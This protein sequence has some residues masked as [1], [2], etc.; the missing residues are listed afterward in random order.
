[1]LATFV[2]LWRHHMV[3][4]GLA[5]RPA[6]A[7]G[8]TAMRCAH[9]P[10]FSLACLHCYVCLPA[11]FVFGQNAQLERLLACPASLSVLLWGA[12]LSYLFGFS[13]LPLGAGVPTATCLPGNLLADFVAIALGCVSH[14]CV[15]G[16]QIVCKLM[17]V[18]QPCDHFLPTL[19]DSF[20]FPKSSRLVLQQVVITL[21]LQN[22]CALSF[23]FFTQHCKPCF[24]AV[25]WLLYM[26]TGQHAPSPMSTTS[27]HIWNQNTFTK[28]V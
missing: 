16:T 9:L 24:S 14:L 26:S 2:N 8:H 27:T 13:I 5:M 6:W 20:V 21:S 10:C 4:S 15:S 22:A 18:S 17:S 12:C 23:P 1:M 28:T 25:K 11:Q 19:H 3:V 7:R